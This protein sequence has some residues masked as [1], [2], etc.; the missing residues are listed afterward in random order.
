MNALR[1]VIATEHS[2]WQTWMQVGRRGALSSGLEVRYWF[3]RFVTQHI[4]TGYIL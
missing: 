4:W 3:G 2:W 1:Y